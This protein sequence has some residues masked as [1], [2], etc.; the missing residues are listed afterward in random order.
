[1]KELNDKQINSVRAI[2]DAVVIQSLLALCDPAS[3]DANDD[4]IR[5][6]VFHY[7]HQVFVSNVQS[8]HLVHFQGYRIDLI[9]LVVQHVPSVRKYHLID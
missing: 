4:A 5:M 2:Q 7:M 8:L 1:M 9:P 6:N 3:T